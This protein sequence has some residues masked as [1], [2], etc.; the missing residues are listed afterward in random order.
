MSEGQTEG[1]R[2]LRVKLGRLL[3]QLG[4]LGLVTPGRQPSYSTEVLLNQLDQ[5]SSAE[6]ANRDG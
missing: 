2:E 3:C 1:N 4:K 5:I 6:S